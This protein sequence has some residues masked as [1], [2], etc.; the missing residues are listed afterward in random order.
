MTE[1]LSVWVIILENPVKIWYIV[2]GSADDA[3]ASTRRNGWK[4]NEYYRVERET[5]CL[6]GLR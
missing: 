6:V 3:M 1:E 5:D 4:Q 2:C